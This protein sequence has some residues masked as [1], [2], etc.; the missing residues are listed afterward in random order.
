MRIHRETVT[1]TSFRRET[2]SNT[3]IKYLLHT[4]W[5]FACT[6]IFFCWISKYFVC[7][8]WLFTMYIGSA[9]TCRDLL[10]Y[11]GKRTA[12]IHGTNEP[13]HVCNIYT[14]NHKE[15]DTRLL[16]V[17]SP[18]ANNFLSFC[19]VRFTGKFGIRLFL[20]IPRHLHCITT[21]PC[22]ILR[23]ENSNS[24]KHVLWLMIKDKVV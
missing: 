4:D 16:S 5:Q 21:L 7:R 14:M 8:L 20:N 24:L 3:F 13:M 23:S 10:W 18:N 2:P 11:V 17:T 15:Q 1:H 22:E 19:A 6:V 12:R 9:A